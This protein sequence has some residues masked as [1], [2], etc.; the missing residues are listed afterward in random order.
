M[1]GAN[2]FKV[3]TLGGSL[4][5]EA[6]TEEGARDKTKDYLL[7]VMGDKDAVAKEMESIEVEMLMES[8]S[9]EGVW[10]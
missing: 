5:V 4:Y 7:E 6:F 9:V 1:E 2:L 10:Q 3:E 8:G